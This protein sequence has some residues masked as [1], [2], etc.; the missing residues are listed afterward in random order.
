MHVIVPIDI[1]DSV[2]IDS[3]VPESD[4]A[5]WIAATTYP[6]GAR[7]IVKTDADHHRY[8]SLQAENSHNNPKASPL[9]WLDLGAVNR[10]AMFDNSVSSQTRQLNSLSFTLSPGAVNS[11]AL[12]DVSG[13]RVTITTVSSGATVYF[14]DILLEQSIVIDWYG[15]FF[16]PVSRKKQLAIIDMP[17]YTSNVITVTIYQ[18]TGKNAAC[19]MVSVGASWFIGDMEWSPTFTIK[20]YSTKETD[21]FGKT[22]FIK[23]AFSKKL[24][25]ALMVSNGHVDAVGMLLAELRSMPLAWVGDELYEITIIFGYYVDFSIVIQNFALSTCNLQIEGLV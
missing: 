8:E 19:G 20:D 4:Y 11:I 25:C 23:R 14:K 6:L 16:N 5:E 22:T 9:Y 18:Y 2:L 24:S 10:W 12:F 13:Y 21:N 17:V 3:D 7:V 1:T 15:Y